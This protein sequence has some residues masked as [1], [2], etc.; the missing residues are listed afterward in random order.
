MA[1]EI[2]LPRVDMEM[3]SGKITRWFVA[4][5]D[6][7]ASGQPLFEMETDK[8]AMD[9]E[10]P[11]AGI[12][13]GLIGPVG[14]KLPVGAVVGWLYAA[15]EPF[16]PVEP[17]PPVSP[18]PMPARISDAAPAPVLP[19]PVLPAP[20]AEGLRA[21]P[22]A[23]MTARALGVE[24]SG[25]AGSGP[26]GRVQASDVEAAAAA[27]QRGLNREWLAAGEGAPIVYLHGFGADL[28]GWR[29]LQS[30][31]TPGRRALAVDLPGHGLSP[32]G[33]EVTIDAF[34][35][36]LEETLEVERIKRAHL[37]GHSLGGAVAAGLA[38]RRP[39]LVRSLT[40]L[41]PAG[42]GTD[43][44][45]EFILGFLTARSEAIL[46]AWLRRL[47]SD[48]AAL[49]T[50]M[51]KTTL[52][53]RRERDL[54]ET[55]TR[56]AATFFPNGEQGFDVRPYLARYS[57]PTRLVFGLEDQIIPAIHAR[58]LSGAIALHL[59]PGIGHMPHFEARAELAAVIEDNVAAGERRG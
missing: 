13:R 46:S 9:I 37:V 5:G 8:A 52:R 54:V 1:F 26:H 38:A 14:V 45:G 2:I 4:E 58:G 7:V 17:R 32:L 43:I 15:D 55:Q 48:F 56:I 30:H 24:I 21:T 16:E 50:A 11:F 22:K 29:P 44:D 47:A 49:G 41:A 3:Q 40:L 28:N 31:I 39:D 23:R 51:V 59:F 20:A 35:D 27:P 12:V 33:D 6:Q 18:A 34:A 53:Q 25:V 57:G 36:A 10:A 42:L 19:A